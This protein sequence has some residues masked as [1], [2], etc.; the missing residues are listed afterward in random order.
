MAIDQSPIGR[1]PRSNPATYTGAFG[2]IRELMSL[3][4]EA[5]ARGYKPGRF[6]FNVKGGRCET[7][8]GDGVRAVEMHFL[9]DVY[10]QCE[11]CKGRR[12]NR[13]TLEILYR[14]RSIADILEMTV[15]EAQA[16]LEAH[17]RLAPALA[18]LTDVGLGYLRLGQSAAT[19]SG[20]EAQR[21]KL[22]RELGA[23]RDRPHALHPRRAHHRP[24][25]R[26]RA[27]AAARAGPPGGG[28]QQRGRDRAQ[29]G[30]DQERR[31]RDRPGPRGGRGG[32]ADGGAGTPEEVA[33]S[34]RSHTGALL[35][36]RPL[37]GGAPAEA[38]SRERPAARAGGPSS[39]SSRKTRTW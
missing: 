8:Q 25:L 38:R 11:T 33:R 26:R 12:Y 10:V 35:A 14:G 1:T 23:A 3:M 16:A 22:A 5:R 17:P 37:R 34:R 32:R 9:P 7:C 13:E 19:L 36:R 2:F 20:G 15:A 18:T 29:P 4:P 6:S 21:V 24:A 27:Q 39:R 28:G 31:P 30:R